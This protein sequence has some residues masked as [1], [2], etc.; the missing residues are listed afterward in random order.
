MR[1][2]RCLIDCPALPYKVQSEFLDL[3]VC[4]ECALEALRLQGG[5]GPGGLVVTLIGDRKL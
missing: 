3:R 5:L 1:C 4:L 2:Q